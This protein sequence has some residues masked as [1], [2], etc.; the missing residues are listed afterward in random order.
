MQITQLD[1]RGH[2]AKGQF[3]V[4]A[5]VHLTQLQAASDVAVEAQFAAGSG[6]VQQLAADGGLELFAVEV[7]VDQLCQLQ[8]GAEGIAALVVHHFIGQGAAIAAA[9]TGFVDVQLAVAFPGNAYAFVEAFDPE[10]LA[11]QQV[12]LAITGNHFVQGNHVA[13]TVQVHQI[14]LEAL[15]ALV[16]RDDQRVMA[17]EQLAQVA[18]DFQ[19]RGEHL[20]WLRSI[21]HG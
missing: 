19:G 9:A 10:R 17:F 14:A 5:V 11:R 12:A 18:G 4:E 8:R 15:A 21:I 13:V 16:E 1:R 6:N 7:D 3:G 2:L 20:G